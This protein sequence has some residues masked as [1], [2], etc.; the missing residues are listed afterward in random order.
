MAVLIISTAE[1]P[2]A[3]AV[4]GH[5]EELGERVR[6][7]DLSRFPQ[8]AH[9]TVRYTCCGKRAFELGDSDEPAG[10]DE[11]GSVWWRRPQQPD[12]GSDIPDATHRLFAAN[13]IHEALA[14][15]WYA[16][17]AHWINDPARDHVAHRKVKQLRVAQDAGL[18]IPD[19]LITS[20]PAAAR[21]YIDRRGYRGVIYKSFS[22]LEDEWRETRVLRAEELRLLDYV[23]Y[24]PVIFQEY[25]E[26]VYDIRATVV[27]RRIFAAAIH[28]QETDYPVDFRMDMENA[29]IE[30]IELPDEVSSRLLDYMSRL[31]LVYGAI[32]LRLRPDGEYVFLEVNPA[33]QWLFVEEKTGQPIAAAMAEAL[34]RRGEPADG[35]GTATRAGATAN[36]DAAGD[37]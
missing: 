18:R 10:L 14:G 2:H 28:S 37:A 25:V 4:T 17:D 29:A 36:G 24:A 26:A 22:A 34:V 13:E 19:T 27:G 32:D 7:V 5:I 21:S 35:R 12:L 3:R 1:D 23:R 15:L 16:L 31:G 6:L 11:Y 30:P 8:H 9:L 20:D 33:G